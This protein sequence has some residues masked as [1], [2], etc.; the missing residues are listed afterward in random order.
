MRI[1]IFN[2]LNRKISTRSPLD[3][4]GGFTL[5]ELLLSVSVFVVVAGAMVSLNLF[6]LRMM[7]LVNPKVVLDQKMR[8]LST[9]L[10]DD[11]SA[12]RSV[13]VGNGNLAGFTEAVP[14]MLQRGNS[15]ELRI[16]TNAAEYVRY[17]HDTSSQELR[18]FH[19]SDTSAV[20]VISNVT[21]SLV[22][23][24]EDQTGNVVT[25]AAP[26]RLVNI[27]LQFGMLAGSGTPIGPTFLYKGFRYS[28]HVAVRPR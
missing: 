8:V 13:R 22:F 27:D 24:L 21:N 19:S 6:G 2:N 14:G 15:L 23:R 9:R 11:L 1:P 20:P 16:G 18:R 3:G 10:Y 25:N 7:Q 28:D 17:F 12:A 5:P 26:G 4:G